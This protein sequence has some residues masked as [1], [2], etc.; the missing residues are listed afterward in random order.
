[1]AKIIKLKESDI[2]KLVKQVINESLSTDDIPQE[3]LDRMNA[4]VE[5]IIRN[6]SEKAEATRI[7]IERMKS[8]YDAMEDKY[9]KD[10]TINQMMQ[11]H[12]KQK[13]NELSW[14]TRDNREY[15]MQNLINDYK[16][17]KAYDDYQRE[18]IEN[19]KTKKLSKDDIIALFVTA[20][21]G[22]SN[23]WYYLPEIPN[24]VRE[25]AAETGLAI[26][27]AI[28]EYILRGGHIQVNDAE[29]E[30]EVLGTVDM[31]SLLD[32]IVK[33]KTDYTDTYHNIIDDE[34]DADDADIFF[35][36]A[37]MGEITFG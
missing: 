7:E 27:E 29:D 28:G 23:Y 37:T 1:M 16:Q 6:N 3:E 11:D 25:I 17:K 22:G 9:K 34:Y 26:S 10:D 36:L 30:E 2:V 21:E 35:Q 18:K 8:H 15:Y 33:I 20:L 5:E 4:E 19:R 31:D 32:A 24:E 13:E 12:L 14:Y